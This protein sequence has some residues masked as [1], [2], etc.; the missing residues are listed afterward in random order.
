MAYV[1]YKN[2]ATLLDTCDAYTTDTP[3][4]AADCRFV[5]QTEPG[6]SAVVNRANLA[7]AT[8]M[9]NLKLPLDTEIAI[10]QVAAF[11][12]ALP[13]NQIVVDMTGGAAGD[14]NYTGELYLG[15]ADYVGATQDDYDTLFQLLDSE[16]NEVM[17]DG[18]EVA[19]SS[20]AV[21]LPLG[22]GFY[23]LGPVTLGLSDTLP[24]GNY[25]LAYA[26]EATL[27]TL[28]EDALIR[29]DIRGLH[30]SAAESARRSVVVVAIDG[31][32]GPADYT[33]AAALE[34][35]L[36]TL[37]AAGGACTIYVRPGTYTFTAAFNITATDISIIGDSQ[38]AAG[39]VLDFTGGAFDLTIS[40]DRGSLTGV[41]L[42]FTAGNGLRW[43]GN[44]GRAVQVAID[45]GE[46]DITG[47]RFSGELLTVV[48]S[49]VSIALTLATCSEVDIRN[50]NFRAAHQSALVIGHASKVSI[51]VCHFICVDAICLDIQNMLSYADF[52]GSEFEA[53]D[54]L[55]LYAGHADLSYITFSTCRFLSKPALVTSTGVVDFFVPV[56]GA[57][58]SQVVTFSSCVFTSTSA[59]AYQN[60]AFRFASISSLLDPYG[61]RL[62][63]C[64][65]EDRSCAFHDGAG[66][67]VAGV[68]LQ[69]V[70]MENTFFDFGNNP[71]LNEDGPVMEAWDCYA[72]NCSIRIPAVIPTSAALG[73]V[74][75][76]A[77]ELYR[78]CEF[79]NLKLRAGYGDWNRPLVLI[80][81]DTGTPNPLLSTPTHR[82]SLVDGL[83]VDNHDYGAVTY[84]WSNVAGT[85]LVAAVSMGGLLRR[86]NW[87]ANN[88]AGVKGTSTVQPKCLI[89]IMGDYAEVSGCVIHPPAG[90]LSTLWLRHIIL[91]SKG[92]S[93]KILD[94]DIKVIGGRDVTAEMGSVIYVAGVTSVHVQIRNN[95]IYWED[96][97]AWLVEDDALISFAND[98]LMAQVNHNHIYVNDLINL[99]VGVNYSL[100]YFAGSVYPPALQPGSSPCSGSVVQGNT[101][102][103]NDASGA[104][105]PPDIADV[106][107]ERPIGFADNLLG[108]L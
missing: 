34:T 12:L 53:G 22:N 37:V 20:I 3:G 1:D 89:E 105:T 93:T 73:V 50:S 92:T 88:V 52:S 43:T 47:S 76:A 42:A 98:I 108:A 103:N 68:Y 19:V 58:S 29:A 77:V 45:D 84:H 17:V 91:Q 80:E 79:H 49:G 66:V 102:I 104:D 11:V 31:T 41:R 63:N 33:G 81:G 97:G 44:V 56:A 74:S 96:D 18:V 39:V 60:L 101:L 7:L 57:A 36:T 61:I 90:G 13:S 4:K 27:A 85:A 16:Y 99:G 70:H 107:V 14:I 82:T 59:I 26:R 95:Y 65:F 40:G 78:G 86:F 25:R 87:S 35:A 15:N 38:A 83:E 71:V 48:A 8:N 24:A 55:A 106:L 64:A 28:P 23:S 46:L 69:G 30:E 100:I 94:N 51:S 5:G 75:D 9:D 54:G 72:Q 6:T 21:G 32:L 67:G 62:I 2:A 10:A